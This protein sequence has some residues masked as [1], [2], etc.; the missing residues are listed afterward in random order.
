VPLL[1]QTQKEIE[2]VIT[3]LEQHIYSSIKPL[4]VQFNKQKLDKKFPQTRTGAFAQ[5]CIQL[6]GLP[7]PKTPTGKFKMTQSAL[8]PYKQNPFIAFLFNNPLP[9]PLVHLVQNNL[10]NASADSEIFNINSKDNLRDLFV[11]ILKETPT[12]KTD[13]GKPKVDEE[14]L[15]EMSKKYEWVKS[16]QNYNKLC[17]LKST[18]IDR[19]LESQED[20]I[21]YPDYLQHGTVSGRYSGDF[22]QLPRQGAEGELDPTVLKYRNLVRSFFVAGPGNVIIDCD[23]ESLEPH[24]FAH[25]SN[26]DKIRNIFTLNHDFYSTIAI[27]TENLQEISADKQATNY[28]GK[29]DKNRR[30]KAKAYSLGIPYGM[31]AFK[32]AKTLE[33]SQE[34]ADKLIKNYYAAYPNLRQWMIDSETAVRN[35]LKITTQAGRVRRFPHLRPIMAMW[36]TTLL[37]NALDLW[38]AYNEDKILYEKAKAARRMYKNSLNNAKNFQIQS[39]AASVVNR[40]AI[41]ISRWLRE[42]NIKGRIALQVHDEIGLIVAEE[43][44]QVVMDNLERLMVDTDIKLSVKL[45]APPS[46]GYRYSEAK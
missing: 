38:Q 37:D 45:K 39:L 10:W 19:F 12:A 17:K 11:N 34:E 6:S 7:V 40:A 2:V 28:L 25:I 27:D 8:E 23:Y 29:V 31:E 36:N 26:E 18:Y 14:F 44:K 21:F 4:T 9:E 16:L 35:Q 32:L 13:G 3:R 43:H 22:Q 41:K 33:I 24:I 42:N 30:Q 15:T 1:E 5:M 46:N 20:G